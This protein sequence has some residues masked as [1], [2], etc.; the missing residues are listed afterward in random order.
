MS[1]KRSHHLASKEIICISS[2]VNTKPIEEKE[3][4]PLDST[5]ESEYRPKKS[6]KIRPTSPGEGSSGSNESIPDPPPPTWTFRSWRDEGRCI[7]PTL[8][9]EWSWN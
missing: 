6:R 3:E 4:G 7:Y 5:A 2:K 9:Y 1:S 8:S